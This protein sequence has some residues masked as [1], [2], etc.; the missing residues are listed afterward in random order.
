MIGPTPKEAVEQ[1]RPFVKM[2]VSHLIIRTSNI[3]T[4]KRFCDEV[5]PALVQ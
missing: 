4:L 3:E 5:A 2:G 1:L